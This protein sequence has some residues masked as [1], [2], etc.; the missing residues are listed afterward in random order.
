[1]FSD[2]FRY[3]VNNLRKRRLRSWLTMLGIFI[4]IASVVALVGLG[5]G[6][7]NAVL[8]QFSSLGSDKITVQALGG[9]F[10]PP[11]SSSIAELT[12]KDV[13]VVRRVKG[14]EV[15]TNRVLKSA[16]VEIGDQLFFE[17]VASLPQP[18]EERKLVIDTLKIKAEKGRLLKPED[19]HKVFIGHKLAND[20][21]LKKPIEPGDSI[22]IQ[23]EKFEVVGVMEPLGSPQFDRVVLMNEDVMRDL[24]DLPEFV[25]VIVGKVQNIEEIDRIQED[26]KRKLRKERGVKKGEEDFDVRTPKQ[27]LDSFRTIFTIVQAIVIGIAAISLI[28]GAVGITNTMYTAVLERTKEIGIMKSI[29]ARNK[30]ILTV[31]MIESGLLGLVG[32]IIGIILGVTIGKLTEIGS[33]AAMGTTLI[34][35]NFN[36]LMLIGVGIFSFIIGVISGYLP[37]KRAASLR[38]VDALRG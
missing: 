35:A 17:F 12:L 4:G 28:V 19:G 1:M 33:K 7:E 36:P 18:P 25:S 32:G 5:Q 34:Q 37:S 11:G 16:P 21:L 29:G 15:V 10:G 38:P 31:F 2:F 9:S 13:E 30:D 23:G 22:T 24:F 26:V 3:S 8:G 6:L 27:L 20:K 14:F